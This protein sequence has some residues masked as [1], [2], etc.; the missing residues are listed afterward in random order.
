MIPVKE[1][2]KEDLRILMEGFD[3]E[4]L[5]K[6][7]LH[8]SKGLNT[9]IPKGF[10]IKSLTSN[11]IVKVYVDALKAGE[12]SAT[13][14]IEKNIEESLE[15]EG[16]IRIYDECKDS[17]EH[18]A[19][20]VGKLTVALF[21]KGFTV[22]AY[23]ILLL[24]GDECTQE[25]RDV[26]MLL[27][28]Y[29]YKAID[30]AKQ[31][32]YKGGYDKG[33]STSQN[34]LNNEKKATAKAKK[35]YEDLQKKKGHLEENL[36][37][38]EERNEELETGLERKEQRIQQ[39]TAELERAKTNII[40]LEN[41][42][43]QYNDL[44]QEHTRLQSTFEN[45]IEEMKEKDEQIHNLNMAVDDAQA[46]AFSNKVLQALCADVVDE[47]Q[48][49][50]LSRKEILQIAKTRFSEQETILDAWNS[51]GNS[52]GDTLKTIIDEFS[53]SEFRDVHLDQ[54]EEMEDGELLRFSIITSL[55]AVL[56][57]SLEQNELRDIPG[58][59]F[60]GIGRN[61]E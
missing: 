25:V 54:L 24:M 60:G 37:Q 4:F 15:S 55:K 61:E 35:A 59:R 42:L 58:S 33:K 12:V 53:S 27:N 40:Q 29:Y 41:Q 47:I 34:D 51:I 28:E 46:K 48:A 6:P 22:P 52:S 10:R 19:I 50:S 32:G 11:Q 13:K 57:H 21:E 43:T 2:E 44:K 45:L 14:Y 5:I 56:F 30:E 39:I 31:D 26:S 23:I 18:P 1:L 7:L 9:F 20:I 8:P 38:Q 16:I 36:K 49:S 3:Q 17:N